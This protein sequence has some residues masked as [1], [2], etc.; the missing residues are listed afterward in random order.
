MWCQ[1]A[2][3]RV[4]KSVGRDANAW[5]KCG[6]NTKREGTEVWTAA[7]TIGTHGEVCPWCY[8]GELPSQ[9]VRAVCRLWARPNID[10][11]VLQQWVEWGPR[12][13]YGVGLGT[14]KNKTR[15]ENEH[16]H[17]DRYAISNSQPAIQTIVVAVV[18]ACTKVMA[19]Y[20][21]T[22]YMCPFCF[23]SATFTPQKLTKLASLLFTC[24]P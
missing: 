5:G 16:K 6:D 24:I 9:R 13:D 12:A 18:Y 8:A 20:L 4:R 7:N 17:S 14:N 21:R 2:A 1:D 3:C 10:L 22:V 15:L 19:K 11:D 23:V